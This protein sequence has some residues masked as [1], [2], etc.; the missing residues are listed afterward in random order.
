MVHQS[1]RSSAEYEPLMLHWAEHFTLIAP[2]TPGFGQSDALGGAPEIDDV[3]DALVQ[4][5][6]ALGLE[7]VGAYGF[8]SGGII[9]VTAL[10][11]HPELFS[12][13]AIGGYAIWTEEERRSF[14][15]NYLPPFVPA[16]YGEHLTWLWNRILEQSWFFPWFDVSPGARLPGAHSSPDRVDAVVREM[17]DSGAAYRGGYGAVLRAPRD[18][19]PADTITPP[20]LITAYDGDPLQA[21]LARLG[22]L[23]R[24]WSARAVR[25]PAEHQA[26]SLEHLLGNAAPADTTLP[27]SRDAGFTR[28]C[29][30]TYNGLIHWRGDRSAP[31]ILLHAPGS[32]SES[33]DD[34]EGLLIDLPG[35]GLSDDWAGERPQEIA[36]WTVVVAAVIRAISGAPQVHIGGNGLSAL[37]ALAVARELGAASVSGEKAHIPLEGE[38]NDWLRHM[39]GTEPDRF[40]HYLTQAWSAVRASHFFWPWYRADAAHAIPF[41]ASDM[42]PEK[43]AVEHRDLIRARSARALT[44][45]LLAAEREALFAAAPPV[46]HWHLADWA[47]AREDIWKPPSKGEEDGHSRRHAVAGAS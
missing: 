24:A 27:E 39:H 30:G 18:I 44:A 22:A 13:V 34:N 17:L 3:A 43:L 33:L 28:V 15:A 2:D 9:L 11:R 42:V 47:Q 31:E 26:A 45:A 12:S 32:S 36:S 20:V 4:F 8:H 25:T 14:G 38:A 41:E 35:H 46:T 5:V 6:R 19:P 1:P 16:A 40:G 29:S 21:H 7:K 37:L 23:P 10:R